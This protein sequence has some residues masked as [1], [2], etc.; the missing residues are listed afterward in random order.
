MTA[1]AVTGYI[2]VLIPFPLMPVQPPTTT[3]RNSMQLTF[4]PHLDPVLPLVMPQEELHVVGHLKIV[5]LQHTAG[6]QGL[7]L[8]TT[9]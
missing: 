6:P 9:V 2:R 4:K 7:C 5:I 1:Q 3:P 8:L